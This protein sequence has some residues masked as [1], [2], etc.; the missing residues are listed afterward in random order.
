MILP[1]NENLPDMQDLIA[2]E[3]ASGEMASIFSFRDIDFNEI[4]SSLL[5]LPFCA[6]L[7]SAALH[8]HKVKQF[9]C[10][11]Q[12]TENPHCHVIHNHL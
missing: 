11:I 3:T 10:I 8:C 7:E 12:F 9:Y 5:S 4:A 1:T 6:R 2:G